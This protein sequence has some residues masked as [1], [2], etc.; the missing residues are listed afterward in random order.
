MLGVPYANVIRII[1]YA[2]MCTHPNILT[3]CQLFGKFIENLYKVHQQGIKWILHYLRGTIDIVLVYEKTSSI[4]S[5]VEG[6]VNSYYAID[7]NKRKSF[8]GYVSFFK[9]CHQLKSKFSIYCFLVYNR[10]WEYS[11]DRCDERNFMSL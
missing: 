7:L 11:I 4:R 2:I 3:C 1:I 9:V 5:C 10:G 8:T 6:F